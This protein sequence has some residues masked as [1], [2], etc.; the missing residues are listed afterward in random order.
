[1]AQ[2]TDQSSIC[3]DTNNGEHQFNGANRQPSSQ[4]PIITI[5]VHKGKPIRLQ[6]KVVVP[7]HDH[8][9]VSR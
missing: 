2:Y 1:M 7:I 4:F 6:V 5:D 9:N 3:N 8:P